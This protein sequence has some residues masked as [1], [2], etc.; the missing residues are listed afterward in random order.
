MSQAPTSSSLRHLHRLLGE[1][2]ARELSD[3]DLLQRFV[4]WRDETAFAALVE[5]HGQLVLSVCRHVLHHDHDAEDSFQATFLVL[6]HRAASIRKGASL[7]SW[8]HG[9]AQR[10]ALRA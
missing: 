4:D 10:T 2:A 6:A 8:L 7:A 5:R 3:G 1:K 9:V